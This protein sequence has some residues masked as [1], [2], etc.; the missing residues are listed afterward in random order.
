M[1]SSTVNG[2][3]ATIIMPIILADE[4]SDWE[5]AKGAKGR[6]MKGSEAG[7]WQRPFFWFPLFCFSNPICQIE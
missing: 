7:L 3:D 2:G 5:T 1:E 4:V 6:G